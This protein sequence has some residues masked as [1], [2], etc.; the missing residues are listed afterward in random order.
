MSMQNYSVYIR[1]FGDAGFI[2]GVNDLKGMVEQ[3][4]SPEGALEKIV[5]A[6]RIRTAYTEKVNIDCI[7]ASVQPKTEN[8]QEKTS[9]PEKEVNLVLQQC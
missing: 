4:N 6:L 8:H 5:L 1:S 7:S 2:A 3:A 9:R